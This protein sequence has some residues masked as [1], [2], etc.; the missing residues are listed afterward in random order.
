MFSLMQ[1][2]EER[3]VRNYLSGPT[4][5]ETLSV[6]QTTE[7]PGA[8]QRSIQ[9]MPAKIKGNQVI[10]QVQQNP[11][12]APYGI[13][14]IKGGAKELYAISATNARALFFRMVPGIPSAKHDFK[15]IT[16]NLKNVSGPE[17]YGF[18]PYA[19]RKGLPKRDFMSAAFLDVRDQIEEE[20]DQAIK[21]AIGEG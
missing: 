18:T 4:S 1:Q 10:G 3:I 2:L 20:L 5:R 7:H 17:G 9:A 15:D 12:V 8:L 16:P 21:E 11:A 19:F 6:G 13:Y 14:H